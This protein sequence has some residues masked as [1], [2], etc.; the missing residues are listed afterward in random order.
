MGQCLDV[1]AHLLGRVGNR[2]RREV[3]LI[4]QSRHLSRDRFQGVII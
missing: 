2:S 3:A 1:L 4:C